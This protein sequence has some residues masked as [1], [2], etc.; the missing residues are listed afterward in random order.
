[1]LKHVRNLA[2]Y[3]AVAV[4]GMLGL[5]AC[6]EPASE[7]SRKEQDQD[8]LTATLYVFGTKVDITVRGEDTA[9]L[10]AAV[11]RLQ[12]DFQ[13]MHKD[14]HAWKAGELVE[15]NAALAAGQRKTVTPF[16]LP[17]IV[18]AKDL[19]TLSDGL[20]NPAIGGL[21][22][23]WGFHADEKPNGALPDLTAIRAMASERPSMDDVRIDGFDVSSANRFVQLDFG[24]FAKG[25]ALDHAERVLKG[26]GVKNALINAGGDINTLGAGGAVPWVVGIRDPK[27][28]G[29]IATLTL[30]NGEDV[31]TS[32][33]YE[34]FREV[35]GVRYAHIIDPRTGMPVEHIVSATVITDGGALGDGAAT[36]LSVAGPKDWHRIARKMGIKYAV[37]VD[38]A[39]TVY[40]NPAMRARI[41]F[42]SETDLKIVESPPL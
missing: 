7:D 35:D 15:L 13:H 18:Q 22:G 25:V 40:L 37:L 2:F 5:A 28:W 23:A 20:F 21:I 16:L 41:A 27:A 34:R 32:G 14:W 36:A 30:E 11:A 29:I 26:M 33:N 8:V 39:G 17:L 38:D 3:A 1:M 42:D 12:D 6:G 9:T 4:V 31:Y 24:G 10:Q 19:Y